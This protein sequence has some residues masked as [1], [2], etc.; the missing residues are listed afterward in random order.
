MLG[1]ELIPF[2]TQGRLLHGAAFMANGTPKFID[3]NKSTG[4]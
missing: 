1:W 4:S 3:A 2:A